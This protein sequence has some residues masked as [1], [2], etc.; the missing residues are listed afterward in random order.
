MMSFS[1]RYENFLAVPEH[2]PYNI[3]TFLLPLFTLLLI[4]LSSLLL[5]LVGVDVVVEVVVLLFNNLYPIPMVKPMN[6]T[7][8]I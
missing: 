7:D 4:S 2:V 6:N 5:A 1:N 3:K 8:T